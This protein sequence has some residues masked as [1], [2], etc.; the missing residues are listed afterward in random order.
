MISMYL[1]KLEEKLYFDLTEKEFSPTLILSSRQVRLD[2][3]R[4]GKLLRRLSPIW[5]RDARYDCQPDKEKW[6]G[7]AAVRP[8]ARDVYAIM[9]AHLEKYRRHVD[10][11][12]LDEAQKEELIHTVWRIMEGFVDRAFA[13]DTAQP[14]SGNRH[15]GDSI[16]ARKR[17]AS[18][19]SDLRDQFDQADGSAGRRKDTDHEGE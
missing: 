12:D 18:K 8:C 15:N 10:G 6:K 14:Q 5:S 16:K 17:V 1:D 2:S 19:P 13:T 3:G 7:R 9:Q 4:L 11:F